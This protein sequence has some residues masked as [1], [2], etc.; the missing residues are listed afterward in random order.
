[1]RDHEWKSVS[2][3]VKRLVTEARNSREN[4][5]PLG[6]REELQLRLIAPANAVGELKLQNRYAK[7]LARLVGQY[8]EMLFTFVVEDDVA[9]ENNAAERGLR[10]LVVNRKVSFGSR[11]PEGAQRLAVMQSIA[12]TVR[13]RNE[14]FFAFA[15]GSLGHGGMPGT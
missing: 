6:G 1:M 3:R 2:M 13:L 8:S 7:T 15:R 14:S 4:G 10:P 9:W 5:V 12:K 11:S